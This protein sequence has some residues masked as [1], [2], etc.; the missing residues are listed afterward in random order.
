MAHIRQSRPDSGLGSQTKVPAMLC[1]VPSLLGGV[2]SEV[3]LIYYQRERVLYWQP[4]PNP[5]YHRHD[6]VDRPRVT[7]VG[8]PFFR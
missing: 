5:L 7:G 8:I 1:V 4:T 2:A 6:L 3:E